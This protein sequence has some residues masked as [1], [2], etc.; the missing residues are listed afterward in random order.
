MR[1]AHCKT[2]GPDITVAHVRAC[3]Q[4]EAQIRAIGR[5]LDSR[6][7]WNPPVPARPTFLAAAPVEGIYLACDPDSPTAEVSYYKVVQGTN[8]GNWYAKRWDGGEWLY[9]GRKP[10]HFI[11]AED[12][13]T[14]EQAARFGHVTGSC[15][16]CSRKL[17]DER[18]IFVGYGPTCAGHNNLPWG[19]VAKPVVSVESHTQE[20]PEWTI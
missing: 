17:T 6:P 2:G 12:K 14:A 19:E 7:N 11:T 4:T 5:E 15:V 10:L 8:T 16:F 3:S 20:A 13:V 18:S 1:C 9:A